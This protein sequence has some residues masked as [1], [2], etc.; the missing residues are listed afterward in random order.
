MRNGV[1]FKILALCSVLLGGCSMFTAQIDNSVF[2]TLWNR[3]TEGE[4]TVDATAKRTIINLVIDEVPAYA[5]CPHIAIRVEDGKIVFS[6]IHRWAE[7]FENA[8]LRVLHDRLSN[9]VID[10]A[11]IVSSMHAI[12][13][14]ATSD[15]RLS[16][17]FDDLIYCAENGKVTVKCSWTLFDCTSRQQVLLRR[18]VA[19]SGIDGEASHENIVRAMADALIELADDIAGELSKLSLVSKVSGETSMKI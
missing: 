4:K 1:A 16:I 10:Y 12:G 17:D 14:T 8:C 18:Y 9:D 15:Y 19:A 11:V 2:Y 5:D 3:E 6:S 7:P 13:N